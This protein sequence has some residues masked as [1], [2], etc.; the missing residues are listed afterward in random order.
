M[1]AGSAPEPK[2]GSAI[3]IDDPT[4]ATRETE[5]HYCPLSETFLGRAWHA[6]K[7]A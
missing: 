2:F 5:K 1:G 7:Q 6:H 3:E 4:H